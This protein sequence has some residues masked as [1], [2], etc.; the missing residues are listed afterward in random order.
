MVSALKPDTW[1][2]DRA[3]YHNVPKTWDK[4]SDNTGSLDAPELMLSQVF[5]L[6]TSFP[7]GTA[8]SQRNP[9]IL[10]HSSSP[11]SFTEW[12][13]ESRFFLTFQV[14]FVITSVNIQPTIQPLSRR[15][16]YERTPQTVYVLLPIGDSLPCWELKTSSIESQIHREM[17]TE[18]PGLDFFRWPLFETFSHSKR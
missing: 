14:S 18:S 15:L 17:G 13:P 16:P 2:S 1:K 8:I 10:F 7:E 12:G 11:E 6:L 9:T 5:R 3:S 4:E